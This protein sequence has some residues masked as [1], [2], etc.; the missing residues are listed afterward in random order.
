MKNKN[1]II[2]FIVTLI[3]IF[4]IIIVNYINQT[5]VS[6][7]KVSQKILFQEASSLFNNI[8]NTRLWASKHGGV[9][10]KAHEGIEPNPYLK[11]NHTYTKDNELLIKI[12]PAWMTRQLSE[13]SN[14]VNKNYYFKITSLNPK[15][16]NNKADLFERK[17]LEFLDKNRDED[18][19]TRLN[20]KSYD[21][22]GVLRVDESCLNCHKTQDYKVGDTMGGLRVSIP[23]NVYSQNVE[24]IT[25]KTNILYVITFFTSIVFIFIISYTINSIYTRERNILRLNKTLERKVEKRTKELVEANEKLLKI[26]TSDFLTNIPN[27]RYFFDM[28]SKAFNLAKRE[29]QKLCVVCIDIDFFKKVND[30]FGHQIGD[31]VLK[32]VSSSL[33][34]K[35]RKSDILARTGGEEFMIILNNTDIQGASNLSEKIRN[36]FSENNFKNKKLD[37]PVTIS[38]GISQIKDIDENLDT[39][40]A[41]ADKALYKSKELGRNQVNVNL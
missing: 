7:I 3:F 21:L 37:I 19:Y 30:T 32:F 29:E 10:V 26:S 8:V 34:N 14:E 1:F 28:G 36:F 41:R 18:F 31:E 5:K 11:D 27:R 35:I 22:L 39:I 23:T 15:N 20:H 12:N 17:A 13:L 16:P 4:T 9:Y 24:L 33:K 6:Y 40:I 38:I 25:S 2:Y